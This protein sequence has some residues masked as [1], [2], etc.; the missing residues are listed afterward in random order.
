VRSDD[1]I[2]QSGGFPGKGTAPPL[3]YALFSLGVL[4]LGSKL[5]AK[6]WVSKNIYF[7]STR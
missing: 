7:S 1:M 5:R 2:H 6:G 4:Y 3:F